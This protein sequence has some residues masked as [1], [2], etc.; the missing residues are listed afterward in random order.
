MVSTPLAIASISPQST[1]T[2]IDSSI[3]ALPSV[4]TSSNHLSFSPTSTPFGSPVQATYNP[5]SPVLPNLFT[6]LSHTDNNNL[7]GFKSF[8][9]NDPNFFSMA[10]SSSTQNSARNSTGS[11]AMDTDT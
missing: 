1:G 4:P 9:L 6:G 11:M 3:P 10:A 2:L 7:N 8:D 5:P